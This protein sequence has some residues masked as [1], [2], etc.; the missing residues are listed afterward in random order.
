[1][2]NSVAQSAIQSVATTI[3]VFDGGT[4]AGAVG[5]DPATWAQKSGGQ[6]AVPVNG[7]VNSDDIYGGP[8]ARHLETTNVL[9]AD[10]HVK[11]LRPGKFWD[12][13]SI[14]YTGNGG[15]LPCLDISKGCQ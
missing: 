14:P 5:S 2:G 1:V 10:G 11:A 7:D 6:F 9:F 15:R 4:G 13:T 8:H 3:A 12:T